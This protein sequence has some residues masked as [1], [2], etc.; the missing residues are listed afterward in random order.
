MQGLEVRTSVAEEGAH[1]SRAWQVLIMGPGRE[2][3]NASSGLINGC[4]RN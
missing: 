3:V 4:E 2:V 1:E